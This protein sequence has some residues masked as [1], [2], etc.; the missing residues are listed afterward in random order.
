MNAFAAAAAS[1]REEELQAELDTLFE[2]QNTSAEG[3]AIPATY[4]RVSVRR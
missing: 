3:T 2:E 4:L 1:G